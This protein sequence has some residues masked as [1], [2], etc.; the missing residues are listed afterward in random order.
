MGA[1]ASLLH[2]YLEDSTVGN[3]PV[4]YIFFKLPHG[5]VTLQIA[6]SMQKVA[7]PLIWWKRGLSLNTK[8]ILVTLAASGHRHYSLSISPEMTYSVSVVH[9]ISSVKLLPDLIPYD[10]WEAS[11]KV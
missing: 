2:T 5:G 8:T 6:N 7:S 11:M 4:A 1:W 10:E 9:K 3:V